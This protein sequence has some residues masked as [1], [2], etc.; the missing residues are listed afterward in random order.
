MDGE[1]RAPADGALPEVFVERLLRLGRQLDVP[2]LERLRVRPWPVF[3][4]NRLRGTADAVVDALRAEGLHPTPVPGIPAAFSVTSDERDALTRSAPAGSGALYVQGASSQRCALLL[5]ARPG[6]RVLDL[7]AAPG[8]KTIALA[9][10]MEDR[11]EIVAVEAVRKRFFRLRDNLER[12]G[13]H[14][15][16]AVAMD[17]RRVP[18]AWDGTFDRVLLD[19][20]C[21]SEA[22]FVPGEPDTWERWSLRKVRDM[23]RKQWGLLGAGIRCLKP[24]GILVYATCAFAPEENEATVAA[25]VGQDH[26]DVELVEADLGPGAETRPGL[27]TW[28]KKR[29]PESLSLARRVVPDAL[30]EGFFVAKLRR[31]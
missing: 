11:G 24:G 13:V 30:H 19:A 14:C 17:G 20:P 22:R 28:E 23:A 16:R 27:S 1:I 5:D 4:I 6:H 15:A 26:P 31:L 7:A 29:W 9:D 25:W 12:A 3:R 2:L 10:G 8:G 21:S 18:R